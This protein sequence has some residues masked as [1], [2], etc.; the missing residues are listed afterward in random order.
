MNF[1]RHKPKPFKDDDSWRYDGIRR[2]DYRHTPLDP[3]ATVEKRH[4]PTDHICVGG[5]KGDRYPL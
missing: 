3:T 5:V 2:R 4:D 1:K